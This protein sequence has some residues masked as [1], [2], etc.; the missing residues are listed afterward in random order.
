MCFVF[1]ALLMLVFVLRSAPVLF[2]SFFRVFCVCLCACVCP[3]TPFHWRLSY[4]AA[5]V[6]WFVGLCRFLPPSLDLCISLAEC[7]FEWKTRFWFLFHFPN[8]LYRCRAL[9][10][11]SNCCCCC[12]CCS[13]CRV[14]FVLCCCCCPVRC[15]AI[16]AL[17]SF[18]IAGHSVE[19]ELVAH[20][21]L[22]LQWREERKRE[23][24]ISIK[25]NFGLT[26]WKIFLKA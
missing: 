17:R 21:C 8:A 2:F 18:R 20:S 24:A 6:C 15:S 26:S 13:P 19:R 14:S 23:W 4:C 12:C 16:F 5:F 7:K 3:L 22:A 1:Y 10:V 25:G 9:V 11:V